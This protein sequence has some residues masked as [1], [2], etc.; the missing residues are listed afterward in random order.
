MS[1]SDTSR[2]FPYRWFTAVR[3]SNPIHHDARCRCDLAHTRI[4]IFA[5]PAERRA[6]ADAGRSRRDDRIRQAIEADL[7]G[8]SGQIQDQGKDFS[9]PDEAPS[10]RRPAPREG[11]RLSAK[12]RREW[13]RTFTDFIRI[14]RFKTISTALISCAPIFFASAFA[15]SN[16]GLRAG[17]GLPSRSSAR[18]RRTLPVRSRNPE[19]RRAR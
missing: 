5:S 1:R 10:C 11:P 17:F 3:I 8:I 2:S 4:A 13:C 7:R 19:R 18:P 9:G 15:R 12:I 16:V 6:T 14:P